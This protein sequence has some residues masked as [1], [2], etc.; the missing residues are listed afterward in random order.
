MHLFLRGGRGKGGRGVSRKT[1]QPRDVIVENVNL[2]YISDATNGTV[3]TKVLLQNA[4]L[5]LLHGRVYALVGKNG[6]GKSTLLRRMAH[7]KIPGFTSLHLKI[8]F[9]PQ[10]IFKMDEETPMEV[11]LGYKKQNRELSREVI[12]A[13][14]RDLENEM[15]ALD[16]DCP[17]QGHANVERMEAICNEI[18]ILEE[19]QSNSEDVDKGDT[20][21]DILCKV[22]TVLEYFGIPK[23]LHGIPMGNLSGGE[24]KKVLLACSLFCDLD[25]LLLDGKSLSIEIHHPISLSIFH[26]F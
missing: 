24:K 13:R 4:S 21:S 1:V 19:S 14:I 7:K 16:L 8:Q 11:I 2:E 23:D 25:I 18:S 20:D 9:I 17:E 12:S 22:T 6:C 26:L 15:E 5:K 3:G 10:E